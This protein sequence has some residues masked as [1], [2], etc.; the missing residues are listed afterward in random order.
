MMQWLI[1][2]PF[3]MQALCIL[4]DEYYFHIKRGL[5]KFERIGHPLD[6]FTVIVCLGFVLLIPYSVLAMKWY[7]A[8]AIFS[9]L[10][11]TK[12]EWVHKHVC[13]ASEQWLHALLFVNHPIVLASMG[14]I[15]WRMSAIEPPFW[16]QKWLSHPQLLQTML[17]SQAVFVVLFF[18]Y[19][20]IYW[21]F[22][23]KEKRAIQ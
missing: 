2:I 11:V 19:Q 18:F 17:T 8:L 7:I 10:F 3:A 21:N 12:D 9:C 15:W 6:T 1:M 13:P 16:V 4:F 23:W 20:I 14:M 22:I 5:P